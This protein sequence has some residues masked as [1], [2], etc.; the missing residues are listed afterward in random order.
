V[1]LFGVT[2]DST[3]INF[4]FIQGCFSEEIFVSLKE[5]GQ[6]SP[7]IC[8]RV[9]LVDSGQCKDKNNYYHRFKTRLGVD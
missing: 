7:I 4:C 2:L 3:K 1:K 5:V 6:A 8:T 9:N